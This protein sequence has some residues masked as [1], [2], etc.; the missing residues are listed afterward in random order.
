[1]LVIRAKEKTTKRV[2]GNRKHQSLYLD[3]DDVSRKALGL[4][5]PE[6]MKFMTV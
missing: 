5:N 4:R 3:F 6:P 1:M 2:S